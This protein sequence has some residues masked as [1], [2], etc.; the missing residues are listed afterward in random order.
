MTSPTRRRG[1]ATGLLAASLLI[2]ST[3][4]GD[5]DTEPETLPSDPATSET[6]STPSPSEPTETT[7]EPKTDR[8]KAI[9]DAESVIRDFKAFT[10]QLGADPE[11]SVDG[12][13]RY[14]QDPELTAQ[15]DFR[16]RFRNQGFYT[17]GGQT[18]F[19]WMRVTDVQILGKKRQAQIS[20]TACYN[21]DDVQ[22][23][24][25]NGKPV[26]AITPGLAYYQ[27]FNYDYPSSAGW[28]I[29]VEDIPGKRCK[30]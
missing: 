13:T 27:V 3:A 11:L 2:T 23:F 18:G 24:Y 15:Q 12:L 9:A 20:I 28:K 7:D 25:K 4:C 21:L 1:I 8:Q 6:N 26:D 29:A 19:D 10:D 17:D 22:A 5:D 30:A 16:R 14:L